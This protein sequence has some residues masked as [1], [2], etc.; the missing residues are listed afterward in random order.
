MARKAART[1]RVL[2]KDAAYCECQD[3]GGNPSQLRT[4]GGRLGEDYGPLLGVFP[5]H[6]NFIHADFLHREE[7]L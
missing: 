1:R 2:K 7:Y 6:P 4:Q 3:A 5:A